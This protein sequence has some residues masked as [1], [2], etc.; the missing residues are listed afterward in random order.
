MPK[1]ATAI[2]HLKLKILACQIDNKEI[3]YEDMLVDTLSS[4]KAT[5]LERNYLENNEENEKEYLIGL[6]C[7]RMMMIHEMGNVI[8][9]NISK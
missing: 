1:G 9:I 6:N 4:P 8:L 7:T 2:P 5:E 3:E